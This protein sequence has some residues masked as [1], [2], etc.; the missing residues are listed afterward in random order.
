MHLHISCRQYWLIQ[1]FLMCR[2]RTKPEHIAFTL[3]HI[4]LLATSVRTTW[5][6]KIANISLI[7]AHETYKN[8]AQWCLKAKVVVFLLSTDFVD[9]SKTRKT[10]TKIS[11]RS[12]LYLHFAVVSKK[13]IES[14]ILLGKQWGHVFRILGVLFGVSSCTVILPALR[15]YR[16]VDAA[17]Y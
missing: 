11:L 12:F 14:K 6:R 13:N 9:P 1:L 15:R 8:F 10:N 3:S 5:Q 7:F 17:L 4:F 16:D 2:K